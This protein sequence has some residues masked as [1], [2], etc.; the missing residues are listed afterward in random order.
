MAEN[1]ADT[2]Q[3]TEGPASQTA[4]GS[5]VAKTAAP[6][7]ETD[8]AFQTEGAGAPSITAAAAEAVR[9][10]AFAKA[11]NPGG[12]V[13]ESKEDQPDVEEDG[14]FDQ[15]NGV[16]EKG[17]PVRGADQNSSSPDESAKDSA[18]KPG[19]RK[20]A[21]PAT[22]EDRERLVIARRSLRLDG[23]DDSDISSM[24]HARVLKL[25]AKA[26]ERH[27]RTAAALR[28]A[29]EIRKRAAAGEGQPAG[30]SGA[31]R[32]AKATTGQGSQ[33]GNA[34]DRLD[35]LLAEL[36]GEPA[37]PDPEA[38]AEDPALAATRQELTRAR[39][40]LLVRDLA[41]GT[42]KLL[43]DFPQL[44]GDKA[45]QS[46]YAR[47]GKL[48]PQGK[49]AGNQDLLHE[50][51]REAAYI[52]FGPQ[53]TERARQE[54]KD[55]AQREREGQ[56]DHASDS[57]ANRA[58]KMTAEDKR[59]AAFEAAHEPSRDESVRKYRAKVGST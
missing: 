42:R 10:K 21:D 1:T 7:G 19:A 8:G 51:M 35:A 23:Y 34:P 52:E 36:D 30:D 37:Q 55:K 32:G 3:V 47:M 53:L 27:A 4:S 25:G 13:P 12:A 14:E 46:L 58:R 33:R 29:S 24:D 17:K 40:E 15:D 50:L 20:E 54:R 49:A 45:K 28:D 11:M 43:G 39:E 38:P 44:R 6:Q 16:D 18:E 59:R 22:A 5:D 31:P 26:A 9:V 2:K 41:E 57:G 56:P 48:D